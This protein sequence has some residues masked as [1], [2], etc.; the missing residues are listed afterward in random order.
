MAAS[1]HWCG[2]ARRRSSRRLDAA[3]AL[4][5]VASE[6]ALVAVIGDRARI[7]RGTVAVGGPARH[8]HPI[9]W[10]ELNAIGDD[11]TWNH[12]AEQITLVSVGGHRP[13]RLRPR[14]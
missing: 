14:Q 3:G 4:T 5:P 10:L 6:P 12:Q 11:R 8:E 13:A 1:R 9:P 2:S 7:E